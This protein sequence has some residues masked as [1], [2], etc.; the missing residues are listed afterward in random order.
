[1]I[2]LFQLGYRTNGTYHRGWFSTE[3]WFRLLQHHWTRIKS[4][5][6]CCSPYR[7]NWQNRVQFTFVPE[8]R[9][10]MW[11]TFFLYIMNFSKQ[12]HVS[13]EQAFG[14]INFRYQ[15]LKCSFY[16]LHAIFCPALV[17]K[18][19]QLL[20]II[21]LSVK[22]NFSYIIYDLTQSLNWV[23][24][25][26]SSSSE[27]Y[28]FYSE[29]FLSYSVRTIFIFMFQFSCFSWVVIPESCTVIPDNNRQWFY[30]ERFS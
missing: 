10:I 5:L 30:D 22:L 27:S 11:Y 21:L 13:T 23:N 12:T 8:L 15:P 6:S 26:A 29:F 17:K 25:C 20:Y 24:V 14:S 7:S 4:I 9:E 16:L 18:Y 19:T 1:M 28:K 2:S 3:G